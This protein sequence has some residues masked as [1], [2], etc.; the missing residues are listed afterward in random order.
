M[1][2]HHAFDD[3]FGRRREGLGRGQHDSPC[4]IGPGIAGPR[5]SAFG[6][7]RSR[8]GSAEPGDVGRLLAPGPGD[9]I[10][11]DAVTLRQALES[12]PVDGRDVDEDVGAAL[13]LD[14]PEALG[15][16]EPL[17]GPL[18]ARP[19]RHRA[20]IRRRAGEPAPG[21]RAGG[22]MPGLRPAAAEAT[23]AI[24]RPAAPAANRDP[25]GPA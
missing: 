17:D 16:V 9:H 24:N 10:E 22:F 2:A 6:D 18:P 3:L 4:P 20:G 15:Y 21:R 5:R 25:G 1:V 13:I 14:E 11:L 12:I 19:L 7:G 23:P 8:T